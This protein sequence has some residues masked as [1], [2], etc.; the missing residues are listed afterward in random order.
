[1]RIINRYIIAEI[2]KYT[3]VVLV[4]VVSIYLAVDFFERIDNFL[5]AGLPAT[6]TLVYLFFKIPFVISQILPVSVLLAVLITFSLMSKH[7][8]ITAL[9]SSGVSIYRLVK[10]V[11]ILGTVVSLLW[12]ILSDTI[13]PP[14][15]ERANLIWRTE[16]QKR[17]AV[18]SREN[19]IWLK[20]GRN[21]IHIRYYDRPSRSI[22]G[23]TLFFFDE[24]FQ[25]VRR[26]DAARGIYRDAGWR[27]SDLMIQTLDPDTGRY[28]VTFEDDRR[29]AIA[30]SPENLQTVVKKPEEMSI[31]ELRDYIHKVE[32]EGYDATRYLVD[33]QAKLALPVVCLILSLTGVGI[34]VRGNLKEGLPVSISY[35]LGVTFVYW[36]FHS[37]CISLGYGGM[38]PPLLAAWIANLIFGC[39]A[40]FTLIHAE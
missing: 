11:F 12:F 15:S 17:E 36:I 27:L 10:P 2:V 29:A 34:A 38:L 35:G 37:F 8:E 22:S 24:T 33:F 1:M 26:I 4:A 5:E 23:I 13:V 40:A 28:A 20:D 7:N 31:G 3:G 25:L 21:M 18:I 14:A 30:L 19:N 6:R 16:V 9:K 32:T 39:L